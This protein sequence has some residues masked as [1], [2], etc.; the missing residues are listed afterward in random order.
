MDSRICC[1]PSLHSKE[2]KGVASFTAFK[3]MDSKICCKPSLH[4]KETERAL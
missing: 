1:R 3:K 2:R 4:S